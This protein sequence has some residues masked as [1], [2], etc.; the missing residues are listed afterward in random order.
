MNNENKDDKITWTGVS[1]ASKNDYIE[2]ELTGEI[3]RCA[4]GRPPAICFIT[5]PVQEFIS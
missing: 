2:S 4:Q 5:D 3:I 1:G